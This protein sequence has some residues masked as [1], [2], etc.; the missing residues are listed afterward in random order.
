MFE[1]M[2]HRNLFSPIRERWRGRRHFRRHA[3]ATV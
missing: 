1:G 2:T 3:E